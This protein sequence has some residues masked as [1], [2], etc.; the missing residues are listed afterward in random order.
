MRSLE[1]PAGWIQNN[2]LSGNRTSRGFSW[3]ISITFAIRLV[4]K[5][6]RGG[7]SF[8]WNGGLQTTVLAD[9]LSPTVDLALQANPFTLEC[10]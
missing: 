1:S 2:G 9:S 5:S 3:L 6:M 10:R 7:G 4:G 8:S